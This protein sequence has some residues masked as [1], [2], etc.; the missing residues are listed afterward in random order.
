MPSFIVKIP[1]LSVN[2]AYC[3]RRYKS[4]EY[5][6]FERDVLL[7]TPRV[8][9]IPEGNLAV[10]FT[11][12]VSNRGA[13]IDNCLKTILDILQSKFAFNDNRV[14]HLDVTKKIVPKGAE[15]IRFQICR[16]KEDTKDL[17]TKK[18]I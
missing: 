4:E 14:Y 3:G 8:L 2:A 12:G 11:F 6:R 15:Y 5:K 13:D 17:E 7:L 16:F 10:S 1:P 18:V 9:E